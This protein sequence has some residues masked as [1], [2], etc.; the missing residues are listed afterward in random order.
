[1]SVLRNSVAMSIILP[2]YIAVTMRS[3]AKSIRCVAYGVSVIFMLTTAYR[4]EA[5]ELCH[6]TCTAEY[7]WGKTGG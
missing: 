3:V 6:S 2:A 4:Y 7:K 5:V 1:M